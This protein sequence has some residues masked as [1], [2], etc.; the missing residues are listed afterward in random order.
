MATRRK[1]KFATLGEAVRDA[2]NLLAHGYGRAGK[3]DLAQC[4]HHL[5]VLMG[6]PIDGFPPMSG[7]RRTVA[8]LLKR[9]IARRWL[10]KVLES[11]V[12]PT[13][14]PT[15][16]RT[17]PLPDCTDAEAVGMLRRAV[18][19]LETYAGPFQESPLFGM[20][21]KESLVAL[22]RIHTAHHLSFLVPKRAP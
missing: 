18:D 12:W 19:R 8:W 20:L 22:H 17:F 16:E 11:G 13:G 14:N 1:L 2:E 4:C 3:W 21:D 7:P 6:W 10:R 15:D 5:A 9:T